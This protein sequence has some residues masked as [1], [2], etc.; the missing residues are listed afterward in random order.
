[1]SESRLDFSR[2]DSR[3][4]VVLAEG[5]GRYSV[6]TV[7]SMP[8]TPRVFWHVCI[9]AFVCIKSPALD[10]VR[11]FWSLVEMV[12]ACFSITFFGSKMYGVWSEQDA[13]GSSGGIFM[14]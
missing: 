3:P 13:Q 11:I 10:V 14:I 9:L 2:A 8:S 5:S 12:V 6:I 1:M 7:G 4:V